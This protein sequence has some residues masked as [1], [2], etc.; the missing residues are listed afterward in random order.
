MLYCEIEDDLVVGKCFGSGKWM[1]TNWICGQPIFRHSHM[2]QMRVGV[3]VGIGTLG[4]GET[5]T[6][7][8]LGYKACQQQGDS[9]QESSLCTGGPTL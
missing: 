8:S 6:V 1:F 2:L 5:D 3:R 7:D 9:Q 4:T